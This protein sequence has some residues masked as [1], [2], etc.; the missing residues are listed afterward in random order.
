MRPIRPAPSPRRAPAATAFDYL[1]NFQI[2]RQRLG[3]AAALRQLTHLLRQAPVDVWADCARALAETRPALAL[4]VLESARSLHAA[5]PVL[6]RL[7]RRVCEALGDVRSVERLLREMLR[8]QPDDDRAANDL[9][10]LLR[11]DARPT[12]AAAVQ[13]QRLG[14]TPELRRTLEIAAFLEGCRRHAEAYEVCRFAL[15]RGVGG[16]RLRLEAGTLALQLGRFDEAAEHLRAALD[17][18]S[19]QWGA[20][21]P[22]ALSRRHTD[23]HEADLQRYRRAWENRTQLPEALRPVAGFALA[24]ALDD[25]GDPAGAVAAAGP[26]NRLERAGRA[27][28]SAA[29]WAQDLDQRRTTSIPALP[30]AL[31]RGQPVPVFVIGLP[32]TGTTLVAELLGRHPQVRNRGELH[33]ISYLDQQLRHSGQ[34]LERAALA[35]AAQ[36]YRRHLRQDD[37]P[38]QWYV[39]KN[40]LN[41]RHLGLIAALF[42]E[43]RVIHCRRGARDTALSNWMQ[44]FDHPDLAWT[45]DFEDIAAFTAS[46][47]QLMSQ[48]P[49]R[50]SLHLLEIDYETLVTAPSTVL[51]RLQ[52]FVGLPSA[53]SPTEPAPASHAIGSASVWQ[54][55]QP[56][57]ARSVGRWRAYAAELPELERRF[58]D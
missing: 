43:A 9:A 42:P 53:I 48:W 41:F 24:K 29:A 40:P 33:W 23:P 3:E 39:D 6:L 21:L 58:R 36:L 8:L 30:A 22:L 1:S 50:L 27:P 31:G 10:H 19:P 38:A 4:A 25:L 57:H 56:I 45:C 11:D 16:S 5:D 26:A 46:H 14:R 49:Q 35:E 34:L 44:L 47:R 20:L 17:A 18:P 32:R 52:A 12:A 7:Q 13:R 15:E 28:W 2:D 55:R 51:P 37:A 54:A